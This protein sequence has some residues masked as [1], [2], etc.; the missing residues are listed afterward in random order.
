MK[1]CSKLE[2]NL[3]LLNN[4]GDLKT[5]FTFILDVNAINFSLKKSCKKTIADLQT[6]D[7]IVMNVNEVQT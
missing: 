6:Y 1:V 3:V 4:I 2:K 5:L 7:L